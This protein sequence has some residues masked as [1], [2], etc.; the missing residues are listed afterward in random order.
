MY[1]TVE[2]K[3]RKLAKKIDSQNLFAASKE[4]NNIRLFKNTIDL[5]KIQQIY[6]SYLFFYNNLNTDIEL[7]K[8]SKKVI[9]NEIYEDSY[10]LWKREGKKDKKTKSNKPRDIHLVFSKS[11]SQE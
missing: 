3:I 4:L 6:L 2:N 7:K 11:K 5:S 8:V 10:N 9:E 1:N